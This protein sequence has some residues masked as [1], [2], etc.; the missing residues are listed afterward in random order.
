[1]EKRQRSLRTRVPKRRPSRYQVESAMT[2]AA[3]TR[4][5]VGGAEAVGRGE[6]SGGEQKGDGWDRDAKLLHEHPE[7]EDGVGV[8]D[9]EVD[10]DRHGR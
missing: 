5:S 1:M 7:E 4:K 9:E 8:C 2:Q 6:G 10:G 3:R